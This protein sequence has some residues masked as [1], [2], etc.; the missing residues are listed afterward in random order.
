MII[1]SPP[2]YKVKVF[3]EN[4]RIALHSIRGQ[5]LR[6]L[7]TALIIAIGIMAL[8]G[9]LTAIDAIKASLSGQ[10]ALLGANT[11][12]IQNRGPNIQ[13]GR[14]GERPKVHPPITWKQA[15]DFKEKFNSPNGIVSMSFVASGIAEIKYGGEKTNPNTTVWAAD[16]NY[17]HTGG[18]EMESGRNI[19]PFDVENASPVIIIG[20]NVK[21]ALFKN[22][23]PLGKVV[24]MSGRHYKVIGVIREKGNSMGFGGDK[25]VFIPISKA[26]ASF[27][28]ASQSFALNVMSSGAET[29]AHN[30]T[31]AIVTMRKVRRLHPREEDNFHI[32]RSDSLSQTLV[33]NLQFVS[34]AA[35]FIGIITLLGA[36]I[37]LMNIMLV[38]VTERTRE[39]GVRKAIGAKASTIR[40]QF[41]TEA[42][43]ICF[44]GGIGGIIFGILIGNVVSLIGGG[45]F[46]IPWFWMLLASILCLLVG[47]I[48]GAYPAFK[49]AALDPIEAL[50]YE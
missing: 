5:L 33:E 9:I 48:S 40:K 8:V 25:S 22:T 3:L 1:L 18:Y 38:S 17:I 39:I 16:E 21:N 23:D 45:A 49:A 42:V 43:L 31:E 29:M 27:S 6:T 50:R 4:L 14:R 2:I 20:Q 10:F 41:L 30:N 28:W 37:A 32:I 15:L 44:M 13:I 26:R 19:T 7:L 34:M 46:I 11:F 24:E 36:A 35:V 12:T 47:L